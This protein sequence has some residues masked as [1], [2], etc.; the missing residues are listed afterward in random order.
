M[1][2]L[3]IYSDGFATRSTFYDQYIS[4]LICVLI[5]ETY[6]GKREQVSYS[7]GKLIRDVSKKLFELE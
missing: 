1:E 3:T 4:M 5:Y 6:A 2:I 7:L